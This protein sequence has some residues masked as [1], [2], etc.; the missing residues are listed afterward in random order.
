M[1]IINNKST[2]S[3]EGVVILDYTDL[4]NNVDLYNEI[5]VRIFIYKYIDIIY[6]FFHFFI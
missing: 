5:E 2:K 1:V 6:I 3:P 4:I